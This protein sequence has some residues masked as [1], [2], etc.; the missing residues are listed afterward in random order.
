M[1]WAEQRGPNRWRGA[2]RVEVGGELVERYLTED[3][4]TGEPFTSEA[5]ARRAAAAKEDKMRKRPAARRARK[6]TPTIGE[7]CKAD[8]WPNRKV[9][10]GTKTRD[11]STLNLHVLPQWENIRVDVPIRQDVEEWVEALL[12]TRAV[13]L[14]AAGHRQEDRTLSPGTVRRIFFVFS[15]IMKAAFDVPLIDSTPCYGVKLPTVSPPDEYF[16]KEDEYQRLYDA[17]PTEAMKLFLE[18][19]VGTGGRYGELTG[20]HRRRIDIRNKSIVFHETW[21]YVADRI[22]TYPKGGNRR[23]VPISGD[24]AE[25]LEDYMRR[26]PPVKCST[27]HIDDQGNIRECRSSLLFTWNDDGDPWPPSSVRTMLWVPMLAAAELSGVRIHDLRHTYASWLIQRG[28]TIDELCELMG[29]SSTLVTKRYAHLAGAHWDR[30]RKVLGGRPTPTP[31]P[32]AAAG[33]VIDSEK[34]VAE[35]APQLLPAAPDGDGAKIIQFRRPR[36]SAS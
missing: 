12:A 31:D 26:H 7:F 30:V 25:R 17:A 29:H 35:S 20:L 33:A 28:I 22:K 19:G 27:S 6:G 10:T 9:Q 36:R 14:T 32:I 3:P 11:E 15:G 1:A 23:G 8:Y 16:L 5:K 2:Y 34:I 21:D 4:E 18:L 13:T 24:L